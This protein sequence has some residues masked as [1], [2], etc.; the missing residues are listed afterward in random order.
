MSESQGESWLRAQAIRNDDRIVPFYLR[1]RVASFDLRDPTVRTDWARALRTAGAEYVVLDCLRPLLDALGLN[2]HTEAGVFLVAFDALLAEAGVA[3]ALVVHHMGHT[4]ER[5]RGDSRLRDWPDAEWRLVRQDD[6]P[7]SPRYFSAYGRDVDVP[8]SQLAFAPE[9]RRLTLGTGSRKDA[10]LRAA[11]SDVLAALNASSHAMS[12]R[13]IVD[14]CKAAGTEHG[15]RMLD[16]A[17]K[18]GVRIGVLVTEPGLRRSV[19]HRRATSAAVPPSVAAVLH[20]T[21]AGECCSAAVPV[22]HAAL[23]SQDSEYVLNSDGAVGDGV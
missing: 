1:G 7:A 16:A 8:E 12:G 4:G 21:A 19:L 11:L 13:A 6:G 3:E 15:E 9:G 18:F 10:V 22:G 5:A 14:A 23:G 17:C 2:E 20:D